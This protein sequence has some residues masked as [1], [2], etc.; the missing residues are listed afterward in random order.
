MAPVGDSLS[1]V[2]A[3][4][5]AAWNQS[6]LMLTSLAKTQ[7]ASLVTTRGGLER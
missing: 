6:E 7:V 5:E 4:L 1:K 2:D 3:H